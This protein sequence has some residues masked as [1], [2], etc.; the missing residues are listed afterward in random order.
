MNVNVIITQLRRE[1]WENK[2]SFIYTPLVLTGLYLLVV[3][4]VFIYSGVTNNMEFIHGKNSNF[5]CEGFVCNN[6]I[7]NGSSAE[8]FNMLA[9]VLKD[10]ASF[11]GI[12]L[13]AMYP[14]C[15]LLTVIFFFV[16]AT[17]TLRCLYEDRKNRE[18]L[19]WRS[20]PVSETTN[21]LVKLA[22]LLLVPPLVLLV[23]NELVSLV[24]IFTGIIVFTYHGV[25]LSYLLASIFN[26][27]VFFIPL[28]IFY[29]NIFGLLMLMPVIGYF[30]FSSA[31]AKKSPFLT[32][33]I[34][35]VVLLV[36]DIML[37][38]IVGIN[39]GI[40]DAFGLYA[41]AIA[42]VKS[43]YLLK[44]SLLIDGSI[45]LPFVVSV[46]IGAVLVSGAI[47]LRNNRYEI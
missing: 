19:F 43:A 44:N 16:L 15:A 13:E 30:L 35:P 28:Q 18:I 45:L 22:M 8:P 39:L 7:Q 12:I 9:S 14:N 10:P 40:T 24:F 37:N 32:S 11:N 20:M 23:I 25:S 26:G 47:W 5:R 6:E 38:K 34:I 33:I 29:E 17:Y 41:S 46:L 31:L 42:K 21:V 27:N 36:A 3:V 1:L 2:G 4:S